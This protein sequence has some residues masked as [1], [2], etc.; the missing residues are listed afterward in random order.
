MTNKPQPAGTAPVARVILVEDND[1]L[2]EELLF[3]LQ[4]SG[5]DVRG[6][7]DAPA[8]GRLLAER[9]CDI[10]LL[11]LNLPGESGFSIA[12]RLCDRRQRGIIMMTARDGIDDKLRGFED[13]ADI[14]LV[15]PV[16]RREL[17]A[18]I[19]ALFQRVAPEP[20]P[21]ERSGWVLWASTRVLISPDG[22]TLAL[23][24]QEFK[25]LDYLADRTGGMRDRDGLVAA[26]G[27]DFLSLPDGRINT[28][29]S[30]LR[31]RLVAFDAELRIVTWRGHGHSYVGP[32]LE[33]REQGLAP[34]P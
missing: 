10:L 1:P 11:D 13:G 32:A 18:C 30:R 8:L 27:I 9:P 17:L 25:V 16:D 29:V 28:M 23:T 33:R 24:G 6:A 15:K 34:A 20:A 2:R 22:R 12:R 7:R 31:Q 5:L 4:H 21:C 14:Y 19:R 26:L 3:Q